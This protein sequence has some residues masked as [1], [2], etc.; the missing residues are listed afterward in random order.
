V[1][2]TR[3]SERREGLVTSEI[4]QGV[5]GGYSDTMAHTRAAQSRRANNCRI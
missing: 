5:G 3:A 1:S 2:G 4:G